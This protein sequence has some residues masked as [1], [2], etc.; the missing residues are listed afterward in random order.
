MAKQVKSSSKKSESKIIETDRLTLSKV[1]EDDASFILALLNTPG[2]LKF[3]GDRGVKTI[4]DA[5]KYIQERFIKSYDDNGFGMYIIKLKNGN[6]PIGLSGLVKRP[7]L[8]DVDIGYALFD[9]FTGK[10]YAFEATKG[11]YN[12]GKKTLGLKRIVAIVNQD[13]KLSIKL[14][15]KL[16]FYFEKM[17]ISGEDELRFYG[18][19]PPSVIVPRIIRI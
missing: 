14:L 18:N 10:G 13:N 7:T 17:I 5:Q 15:E 6:T 2:W 1:T 8:D 11:V 3:I 4:E 12:Y 19:V 16:G 9:D